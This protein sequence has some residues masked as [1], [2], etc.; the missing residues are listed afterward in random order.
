M[1]EAERELEPALYGFMFR[2]RRLDQ[3]VGIE[4]TLISRVVLN[5]ELVLCNLSVGRNHVRQRV[6]WSG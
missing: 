2:P 3:L 5:T 1:L 6:T 4:Y